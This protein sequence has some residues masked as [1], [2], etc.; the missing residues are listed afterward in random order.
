VAGAGNSGI[1]GS[2]GLLPEVTGNV[3]TTLRHCMPAT[4]WQFTS[5][6]LF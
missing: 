3:R 2:S 6:V 1:E 4:F 5:G